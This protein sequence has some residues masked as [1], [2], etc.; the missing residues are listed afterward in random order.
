MKGINNYITEKLHINK[1]VKVINSTFIFKD[2]LNDAEISL[3]F[4]INIHWRPGFHHLNDLDIDIYNIKR[5]IY[6]QMTCY[7]LFDKDNNHV[8]SLAYESAHRLLTRIDKPIV[9][10]LNINGESINY[11]AEIAIVD[12]SCILHI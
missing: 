1:D 5:N 11:F 9:K 7:R 12:D 8:V 10:I 2:D 3:P 6:Q 4:T